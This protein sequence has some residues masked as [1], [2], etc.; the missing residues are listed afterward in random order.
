[1]TTLNRREFTVGCSA[2][3]AAFTGSR[4]SYALAP[5]DKN[6]DELLVVVFLRGGIDG[7]NAVPVIAGDDRGHYEAAR[8]RLGVPL[9][10]ENAALPLNNQF[11]LH[12][13]LAP[14]NELYQ[15]KKMGIVVAS[16]LDENNRSHFE[17]MNY[18]ELGSRPGNLSTTGWLTRHLLSASS[19]PEKVAMPAIAMGTLQPTSLLGS[20]ES[21]AMYSPASV[22]FTFHW[23]YKAWLRH[24]LRDMY[25]SS[26]SWLHQSGLQTVNAVDVVEHGNPNAYA[27]ENGAL[28][29]PDGFGNNLQSVAQMIKLGL[30]LQVATVDFGGWDTH[31]YQG[32]GSG[33][34]F[35]TNLDSLA[36]GLLAFYTDLDSL[37]RNDSGP[38]VTTVVMSEF[39][40]SLKENGSR[41][42]DHGHGNVMFVLGDAVNGGQIYGRWPG[43][44][45]DQLYEHRDLAITTDYRQVLSE[46]LIRRFKNPNLGYVFPDY[47]SYQPL[48]I[49]QGEDLTPIYEEQPPELDSRTTPPP[50]EPEDLPTPV[51][52]VPGTQPKNL[53][54]P[55]ISQ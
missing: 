25:G 23:R 7:L 41:G 6:L 31:E 18:I 46:I 8:T 42:T 29:P 39:G 37:S 32:D 16:G 36:R 44:H 5:D 4:L 13:A 51:A 17:M 11:G 1:M 27:P 35:A 22:K 3:I 10:G 47:P 20:R 21:I 48:G 19:I 24:A 34:Y 49:V 45:V 38:R 28:Y 54:L 15:A 9:S 14:L 33:G 40:R 53:Y 50:S 26:D 52:E 12:P 2:A 43:L 55:L 30:G